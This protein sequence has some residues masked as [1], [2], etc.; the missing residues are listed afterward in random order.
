MLQLDSLNP[1]QRAAV[2]YIDGPQL[3]VAGAGSGKTRVLTYKI[4]YLLEQGIQPWN[5]LA[6]TFTNK[7]ASEMK[8]R[9]AAQVGNNALR[10]DMGTFHSIFARILRYESQL[11]GFRSNYTIYDETDS[12]SLV[13]AI[14]KE[15]QLDEKDYKP[16]N[17][18]SR[19]S[20]AKNNL[21]TAERYVANSEFYQ[22]DRQKKM[23]HTGKIYE[24]YQ[25][26][27]KNANA[28]DF[29]DLLMLT[30]QLF[31]QYPEVRQKYA[32]RYAYILVDEYQDTNYV[33]QQILLQ[34][35]QENHNICVV[36]DDYQ[37]IYGFRGAKIDNILTFQREFP[38][39][40]LF[41]LERNYRS[42]QK[43]VSAANSLMKHNLHQIDKNVYSENAVGE[44]L[45]LYAAA[46][47]R[48]EAMFV[49][50]QIQLL[51]RTEHL[52]TGD[53]AVLY[54]TNAQSRV[55][56]EECKKRG[57]PYRIY[58]GTGFYQRKE[59]KDVLA[60]F[61][62]LINPDDDEALRR[63]VNFPARGIGSTTF[64][65]VVQ[66]AADHDIS[67]WESLTGRAE[68]LPLQSAARNKLAGFVTLIAQLRQVALKESAYE[69]AKQ[70]IEQV[71]IRAEYQPAT[72]PDMAS[73]LENI[74]EL[75]NSMQEFVEQKQEEDALQEIY[76]EHYMQDVA[77]LT[78]V[79]AVETIE[80]ESNNQLSLMTI[81]M[82]KGLEFPVVFVVGLE[83]NLFPGVQ[84]ASSLRQ[85][86][87]ERRLL[88][89]AITRAER[90]CYLTYARSRWQFGQMAMNPQSRFL[91]D[92]DK[93]FIS[94][95]EV[96]GR[97]EVEQTLFS[98]SFRSSA[99]PRMPRQSFTPRSS[100]SSSFPSN[101]RLRRIESTPSSAA[102]STSS[103]LQ[104]GDVIEHER[105]GRGTVQSVVGEGENTKAT[106]EFRNAGVKQLLLKFARY[107]KV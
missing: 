74:D 49:C 19:I 87:E 85:L 23:E 27:C 73:R 4:A 5:I 64:Q 66:F 53:F 89:V 28:M 65:K 60:Y 29:D 93:Q 106:V 18:C 34:L 70:L 105:F 46:S 84:S 17:V 45:H 42:T 21:I 77:L 79:D 52:T 97:S 8:E 9:I 22:A 82:A 69:V 72:D 1:A 101:S 41:K 32:Q 100:Q 20:W 95:D 36:G 91:R 78:S 94:S 31:H 14:V 47:D 92:I 67:I 58:G 71:N 54:R 80:G 7:A 12:R 33:Q 40:Q 102:P 55:L 59:I 75:L 76:L 25:Q 16:A 44:P 30:F 103:P 6:L 56:E 13:K 104:P 68:Q 38:E 10:L 35:R 2:T 24:I 83:E 99:E 48:E 81:H 88:Y 3:V 62:L 86:E 50:K 11:L 96:G 107:K 98:R 51:R 57:I 61:R 39:A 26:R 90:H 37:S 43:I 63:I 15:L